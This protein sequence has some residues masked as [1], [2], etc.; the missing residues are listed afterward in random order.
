[1]D[2]LQLSFQACQQEAGSEMEQLRLEPLSLWVVAA[3]HCQP[4]HWLFLNCV[5]PVLAERFLMTDLLKPNCNFSSV[6][7]RDR[8]KFLGNSASFT[9]R[10]PSVLLQ[11]QVGSVWCSSRGGGIPRGVAISGCRGH[12]RPLK[13]INSP[14]PLSSTSRHS[15]NPPML[16]TTHSLCW[17]I[18]CLL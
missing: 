5:C 16:F 1:M 17:G 10:V 15:H 4:H 18:P 9:E 12:E 7:G 11:E 6:L 14:S 2:H 8:G 13:F 3:L